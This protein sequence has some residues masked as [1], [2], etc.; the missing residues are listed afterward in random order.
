MQHF[1]PQPRPPTSSHVRAMKRA[2]CPWL[3]QTARKTC[4]RAISTTQVRLDDD[5]P[6]RR[7]GKEDNTVWSGETFKDIFDSF[8]PGNA[9]KKSSLEDLRETAAARDESGHAQKLPPRG[10]QSPPRVRISRSRQVPVVRQ[11]EERNP[12]DVFLDNSQPSEDERRTVRARISGDKALPLPPF[13]DPRV[14]EA[15]N[16]HRE[17]KPLQSKDDLTPLQRDIANNPY[18]AIFLT[19]MRQDTL[20]NLILPRFFLQSFST[21]FP[22]PK[23]TP[24]GS[25]RQS[26]PIPAP[27]TDPFPSLPTE[28]PSL[29]PSSP[30]LLPPDPSSS[31]SSPPS[32]SPP[33][34]SSPPPSPSSPP[35]PPPAAPTP[36]PTLHPTLLSSRSSGPKSYTHLPLLSLLSLHESKRWKNL[37]NQAMERHFNLHRHHWGFSVKEARFHSERLAREEA[38]RTLGGAG[39]GGNL[40]RVTV[41]EARAVWDGAGLGG[42]GRG[43]GGQGVEGGKA[44]VIFA[45]P[46][47]GVGTRAWIDALA[48]TVRGGV[49]REWIFFLPALMGLER[50]AGKRMER[51]KSGVERKMESDVRDRRVSYAKEDGESQDGVQREGDWT[52]D[53]AGD[54][55]WEGR[56]VAPRSD[57]EGLLGVVFKVQGKTMESLLFLMRLEMLYAEGAKWDVQE[58]E[59]IWRRWEEEGR[60]HFHKEGRKE[61]RPRVNQRM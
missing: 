48:A 13:M 1:D 44:L 51:F 38:R 43:E 42:S 21:V 47:E 4:H 27:P 18:A 61:S 10:R 25:T 14:Q 29:F 3:G 52:G 15:R 35:P 8:D 23:D 5:G 57:T 53:V 12:H 40:A 7:P 17:L 45:P 6:R 55:A 60:Q 9:S 36:K 50:G 41:E 22:P 19:H 58:K 2:T 20:T 28:H 30:S 26:P 31:P 34:P 37:P 33:S 24:T 39:W 32:S 16:K 49:D 11:S 46:P 54:T 59:Q 56:G